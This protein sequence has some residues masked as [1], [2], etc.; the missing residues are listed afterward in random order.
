MGN[1]GVRIPVNQYC[2]VKVMEVDGN[3]TKIMGIGRIRLCCVFCE[4]REN[5]FKGELLKSI[6]SLEYNTSISTNT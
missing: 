2:D 5:T 3:N 4:G 1:V 6:V